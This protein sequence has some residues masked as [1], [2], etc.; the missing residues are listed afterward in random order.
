MSYSQVNDEELA[1]EFLNNKEYDK[2]VILYEKL[3]KKD[4]SSPYYYQNLLSCYLELKAYEDAEKMI[5]RQGKKF[6]DNYFY[7]V[8]QGFLLQRQGK[9]KDA[10]DIYN[11]LLASLNKNPEN[12]LQLATAFLRRDLP[13]LSISAYM[14]ARKA[15]QSETVFS[16]NLLD[17]YVLTKRNKALV[18]EC[19]ELIKESDDHLDKAKGYLYRVFENTEI[20]PV[21]MIEK[22]EIIKNQRKML[23]LL[24]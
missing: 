2:A 14:V 13:D 16:E 12:T 10:F 8:D 24:S 18:T 23:M 3:L 15:L 19:F 9:T 20:K 11:L 7:K 22:I 4:Y 1:A 17:L 5:K 6:P 21:E